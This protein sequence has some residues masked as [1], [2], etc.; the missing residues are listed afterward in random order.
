MKVIKALWELTRLEHGI[1]III[2]ILVGYFIT[3]Q[4][5]YLNITKIVFAFLTGLLLE[6]STFALN[7]YFD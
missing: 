1:M 6:A 7:D 3:N 5:I 2:A 4:G